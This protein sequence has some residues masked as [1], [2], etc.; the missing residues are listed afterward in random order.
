MHTYGYK[1]IPDRRLRLDMDNAI[2][3][4]SFVWIGV[5][6]TKTTEITA[7]TKIINHGAINC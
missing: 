1:N 5:A 3:F 4:I 6:E 2:V 7:E